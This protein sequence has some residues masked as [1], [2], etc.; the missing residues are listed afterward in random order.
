MATIRQAVAARPIY[1]RLGFR[2]VAKEL[3]LP[4]LTLFDD[5]PPAG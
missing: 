5:L 4:L 1:E 2:A 3:E